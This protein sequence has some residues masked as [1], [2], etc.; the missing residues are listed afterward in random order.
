MK[1]LLQYNSFYTLILYA[2][3]ALSIQGC[4][5]LGYGDVDIDTTRK[6]ILVANAEVQGATLLLKDLVA[7]RAISRSQAQSTKD[8]L[9]DAKD[10][11]QLALNAVNLSGD[12]I[13]ADSHLD[14]AKIGI[15]I[16]LSI[17]GPLVEG[18]T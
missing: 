12:P 14:R 18:S 10:A 3:V 11:L 13:A 4:T 1:R 5:T 17:L 15:R 8:G 9:Q 7:R 6:S 2:F 16:A